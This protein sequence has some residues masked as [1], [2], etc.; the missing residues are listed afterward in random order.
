LFPFLYTGGVG[1]SHSIGHA[2]GAT[3]SIPHGITSCL[4]LAP[5][6]ELKAKTKPEEAKCI[7]RVLPYIGKES[8]GSDEEDSK[9]VSKA[10]AGL[11]EELGHKSTLT[12]VSFSSKVG[13]VH[14][15]VDFFC[16]V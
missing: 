13:I 16:A 10:I 4:T 8:S 7:A 11:V 5:V 1:L 15:K 3:Y 9:V 6:V 2:L 14:V 12:M